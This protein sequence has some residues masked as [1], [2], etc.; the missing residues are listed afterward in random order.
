MRHYGILSNY[1][2][3]SALAAA[4]ASL[5]VDL[6]TVPAKKPRAERTRDL[7][8]NHLGRSLS[9][10]PDCGAVDSLVR[11]HIFP[12]GGRGATNTR[13][14]PADFVYVAVK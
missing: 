11:I 2:K 5:G 9:D 4:R 8:E 7:L 14:P 6:A 3:S 12:S 10:C 13:A 1:H